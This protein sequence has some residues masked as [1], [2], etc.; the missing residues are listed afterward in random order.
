M[1]DS[2]PTLQDLET[3]VSDD[4][5]PESVADA[6]REAMSGAADAG[7]DDTAAEDA[8]AA[9]RERDERGR[10]KAAEAAQGA[11][12]SADKGEPEEGAPQAA[13]G[14]EKDD[15]DD[16]IDPRP[17]WSLEDQNAFRALPPAAQ[18]MVMAKIEA[19]DKQA[20]DVSQ[21]GQK[22]QRLDGVLKEN[23]EYLARRGLDEATAVKNL[24]VLAQAADKNPVAFI[25]WMAQDRGIDLARLVASTQGEGQSQDDAANEN[26]VVRELRGQ[27]GQLQG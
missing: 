20:S 4:P 5:G 11:D 3:V 27:I 2:A 16:V 12:P 8:A 6:L 23:A 14:D 13:A 7:G 1:A 21:A 24:F 19:A 25:Q 18:K 17:E 26:P 15:T 9:A 22:Y 10:F